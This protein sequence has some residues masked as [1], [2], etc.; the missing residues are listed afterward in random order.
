MTALEDLSATGLPIKDLSVLSQCKNLR[1]LYIGRTPATDVRPLCGLPLNTLYINDTQ[2][3]DVSPLA[4]CKTL[5]H[6]LLPKGAKGVEA[7]R[8]HPRLQR[9]SYTWD[10]KEFR[11]SQTVKEFWAEYDKKEN[12]K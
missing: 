12:K 2:I 7:L 1:M 11:V 10:D 4:N 8:N 9:L 3:A 5:E 6:L